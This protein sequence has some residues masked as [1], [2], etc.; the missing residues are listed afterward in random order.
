MVEGLSYWSFQHLGFLSW[1][2]ST[3]GV[4]HNIFWASPLMDV[5]ILGLLACVL[6]PF[7]VLIGPAWRGIAAAILATPAF[8]AFLS[9]S[10]HLSDL[11][12]LV[13]SLGLASA[14]G[15]WME[16]DAE[17]HCA[18]LLRTLRPLSICAVILALGAVGA[19]ALYEKM[20]FSRL[21]PAPQ[22]PNV[23]LIILDT[24]RGDRL[25]CYGNPKPVSPFLDRFAREGTLYEHAFVDA[26][27][28]LPSHISIFTGYPPY[29]HGAMYIPFDGRVPTIA[30]EMQKRGYATAGFVANRAFG[31][32]SQGIGRGFIHWENSFTGLLDSAERTALGRQMSKRFDQ[33][34]AVPGW[35]GYMRADEINRR[36]L[37]WLDTQPDRPFFVF[38][39]YMDMHVPRVPPREFAARISSYPD[40]IS[41]PDK[42]RMRL[43]K[44]VTKF[45]RPGHIDDV[46]DSTV[47]YLDSL[48]GGLFTELRRRGL[49]DNTIVV[50]TSDHGESL[51]EHG[52]LGHSSSLYYD[53]IHV[54]LLIRAPG[55]MPAGL[56]VTQLA[57][58]H[59]IPATI[60][61][62]TSSGKNPFPGPS[63]VPGKEGTEA[64][65]RMVLC[66]VDRPDS[67]RMPA[68]WPTS[69]GWLKALVGER[70]HFIL[71]QNG[72][73]E[74][75]D[76]MA[77][78]GELRDLSKLPEYQVPLEEFR[79][80]LKKMPAVP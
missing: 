27:W 6:L 80:R 72:E 73:E 11:G 36:L 52:L 62:L 38:L 78:P 65:E 66:E 12:S 63:L 13:L 10:G 77:D 25:G 70:L 8:F 57:D 74:L 76:W 50:V 67:S 79:E 42:Y 61:N 23:L 29:V 40:E 1:E 31:S 24:M 21:P 20:Q 55:R 9:L 46:Y 58:A 45:T 16:R 47:A 2:T 39:N 30:E 32:R 4:D 53:Q 26:S 22:A 41:P 17:R 51:G 59:A 3:L 34:F 28:S 75:F 64:P 5:F 37:R 18:Q 54:P 7:S 43:R 56:R 68:N 44:S 35:T 15:R 19:S 69:K 48:L 60:I 71:H 33:W 49:E 14:V